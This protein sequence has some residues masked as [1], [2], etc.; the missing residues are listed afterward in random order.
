MQKMSKQVKAHRILQRFSNAYGMAKQENQNQD[1]WQAFYSIHLARY[2]KGFGKQSLSC[3]TEQTMVKDILKSYYERL[4]ASG[5]LEDKSPAEK[6]KIFCEYRIDFPLFYLS[7]RDTL[8]IDFVRAR[9]LE[10]SDSCSCGSGLAYMAC[11][12]RTQGEDELGA[13]L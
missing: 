12:G 7:E 3:G 9:R 4:V 5:V 8:P 10:Q 1:D 13:G 2:L 6:K 11:C